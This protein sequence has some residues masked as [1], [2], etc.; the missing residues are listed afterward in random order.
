MIYGDGKGCSRLKTCLNVSVPYDHM[1]L[2]QQKAS[3]AFCTEAMTHAIQ[4]ER[5][6]DENFN[7]K[8]EPVEFSSSSPPVL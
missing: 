3:V 1:S 7:F 5:I 8:T 6:I 4:M 2:P